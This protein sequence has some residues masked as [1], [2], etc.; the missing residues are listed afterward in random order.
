MDEM[1][2]GTGKVY[3]SLVVLPRSKKTQ[4]LS[5]KDVFRDTRVC[6]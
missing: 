4:T 2:L 1:K 6:Y 3:P 5:E